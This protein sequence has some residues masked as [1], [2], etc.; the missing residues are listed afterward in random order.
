MTTFLIWVV[1]ENSCINEA[2]GFDH[3]WGKRIRPLFALK[4][5]CSSVPNSMKF[6]AITG[7][8]TLSKFEEEEEEEEE[9]LII[10]EEIITIL[11]AQKRKARIR[12][13]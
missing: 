4:F 12:D 3:I 1:P 8:R 13:R 11:E 7:I 9:I 5:L 6:T 10:C 2:K